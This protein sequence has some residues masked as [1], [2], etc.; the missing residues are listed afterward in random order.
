MEGGFRSSPSD[1][2]VD[3]MYS[4]IMKVQPEVIPIQ[5]GLNVLVIGRHESLLRTFQDYPNRQ[6]CHYSSL[7]EAA[8][9]RLPELVIVELPRLAGQVTAKYRALETLVSTFDRARVNL[10]I[11]LQM[12]TQ[13]RKLPDSLLEKGGLRVTRHCHC[14]YVDSSAHAKLVMLCGGPI[15]DKI[16]NQSCDIVEHF[17]VEHGGQ[18]YP[19]TYLRLI[20][21]C[22]MHWFP[23]ALSL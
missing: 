7:V 15:A 2:N 23:P 3:L 19:L 16:T 20:K 21:A 22:L 8:P 13:T 12:P 18:R 9:A 4:Y 5:A 10:I 11:L 6:F 14:R 1:Q 17:H